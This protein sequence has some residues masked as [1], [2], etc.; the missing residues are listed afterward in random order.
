M[1]ITDKDVAYVAGLAH[2]DLTVEEQKRMQR[3]LDSILGFIASLNELDTKDVPPMAQVESTSA[4]AE[5]S[6]TGTLRPDVQLPCLP[7]E[8][9]LK[10]SPQPDKDFFKVP[11]VIER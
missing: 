5:T 11:K 3:D 4:A 7:H 1:N 2:L 8:A 9:A 10:N 6:P